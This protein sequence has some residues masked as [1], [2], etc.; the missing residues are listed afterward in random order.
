[1]VSS[2]VIEVNFESPAAR[3]AEGKIKLNDQTIGWAIFID[4]TL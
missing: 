3:R 4:Y 1:M 2:D